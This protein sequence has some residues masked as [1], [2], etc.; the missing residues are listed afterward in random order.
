MSETMKQAT[1]QLFRQSDNLLDTIALIREEMAGVKRTALQV[2]NDRERL[3][4][5]AKRLL[6]ALDRQQVYLAQDEMGSP[7]VE[8][9]DALLVIEKRLYGTD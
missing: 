3:M 7:D 4:E 2:R 5:A 1:D 9:R 8:L 6:R